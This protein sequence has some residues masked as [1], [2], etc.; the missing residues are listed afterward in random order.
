MRAIVWTGDQSSTSWQRVTHDARH[1]M[2]K[3]RELYEL[4]EIVGPI[5]L[6]LSNRDSRFLFIR[7]SF[8]DFVHGEQGLDSTE[9]E[10]QAP[11]SAVSAPA[12]KWGAL[13]FVFLDIV[14]TAIY[15]ILNI[16]D[17][18]LTLAQVLKSRN[19]PLRNVDLL[20]Q[21][22]QISLHLAPQQEKTILLETSTPGQ[23]GDEYQYLS[24]LES[25]NI[26]VLIIQPGL[27]ESP[28]ECRLEERNL[29][30]DV[31][32]EALSY[33]WGAPILDQ[34]IKIDGKLF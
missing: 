16:F 1:F 11:E 13:P 5:T 33:V 15:E 20:K 2:D 17:I 29:K 27:K 12:D 6:G 26:R 25:S 28:I 22:Y 31:I 21:V 4:A 10:P 30:S 7:E 24:R 34:A 19:S 23:K 9:W 8:E 18:D 14:N 32:E 3:R